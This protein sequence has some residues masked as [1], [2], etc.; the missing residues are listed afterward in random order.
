VTG[1]TYRRAVSDWLRQFPSALTAYSGGVDSAVVAVLAHEALG[2]RALACIGVSP[3]FP[4]RERRDAIALA[5]RLGMSYRLIEP[6]EQDDPSYAANP[7]HR[8]YFCKSHLFGEL[9]TLAQTEGWA[10]VLDGS[11]AEDATDDR[12]G[13]VAASE[14]GVRSPLAELGIGKAGVRAIARDLG[15]EVWDKPAAAC[16]A[17]RVPHG[18]AITPELLHQIEGAEDALIALGF[19]QLRVRHHGELARIEVPLEEFPHAM[20]DRALIVNGVRTA[21]YRYV[22]LD[23]AGFRGGAGDIPQPAPVAWLGQAPAVE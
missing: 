9:R 10:V 7:E 5:E 18:T 2:P 12:P 17:S 16:L 1:E 3:S 14:K 6:R 19:R 20:A 22:C 11:H 13:R 23:L 21:G 4:E 15:L 8:C